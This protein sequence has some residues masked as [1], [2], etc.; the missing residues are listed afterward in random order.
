MMT[1]FAN[2]EKIGTNFQ[3]GTI[4]ISDTREMSMMIHLLEVIIKIGKYSPII[5]L[6]LASLNLLMAVND[7]FSNS[8]IFGILNTIF[9]LGGIVFL[10][11]MHQMRKN[12]NHEKSSSL[13]KIDELSKVTVEELK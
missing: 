5:F 8:I 4:L 1:R 2:E 13:R 9:A 6:S 11:Q 7:F 10:V 3:Q 12:Q